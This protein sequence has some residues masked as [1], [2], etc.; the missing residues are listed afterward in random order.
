[1]LFKLLYSQFNLAI[2]V[3]RK[4]ESKIGNTNKEF[5]QFIESDKNFIDDINV[6]ADKV[7]KFSSQF[8]IPG[9]EFF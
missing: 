2:E 4:Y 5:K 6:V 3:Y 7:V 1:M 8:D 9:N